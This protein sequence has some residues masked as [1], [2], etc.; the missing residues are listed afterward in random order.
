MWTG[1][2]ATSYQK[3]WTEKIC[4][5]GN[6]R[7]FGKFEDNLAALTSY[8]QS[9]HSITGCLGVGESNFLPPILPTVYVH[10]VHIVRFCL[11]LIVCTVC[12]CLRA[13]AIVYSMTLILATQFNTKLQ[14]AVV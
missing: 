5:N 8:S 9:G 6:K 2:E 4:K 14:P 11:E 12:M 13:Y 1:G 7:C 3:N 10:M